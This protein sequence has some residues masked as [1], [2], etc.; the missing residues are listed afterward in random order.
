M[1]EDAWVRRL[2]LRILLSCSRHFQ[3]AN[4]GRLSTVEVLAARTLDSD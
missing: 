2:G 1:G 3:L 4:Y